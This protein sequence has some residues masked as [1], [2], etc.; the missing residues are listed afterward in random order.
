VLAFQAGLAWN[1][2]FRI[3]APGMDLLHVL[4]DGGGA[5]VSDQQ[6]LVLQAGFSTIAVGVLGSQLQIVPCC[7]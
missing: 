4:S 3:Q 2:T 5:A 7:F 6:T 1:E